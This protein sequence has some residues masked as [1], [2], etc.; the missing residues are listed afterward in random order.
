MH[1]VILPGYTWQCGLKNTGF[2][3][4][5]LKD[6]EMILFLQKIIRG[7]ISS[8]MGDRYVKTDENKRILYEDAINLYGWAMIEYLPCDEIKFDRDVK[9]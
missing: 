9:L 6:K 5:S 7:G 2:E 3:L 8:V 1:C 4:Q